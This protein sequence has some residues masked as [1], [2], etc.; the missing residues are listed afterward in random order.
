[1]LARFYVA[2]PFS[3]HIPEGEELGAYEYSDNGY[4]VRFLPPS[5]SDKPRGALA[6]SEIWINGRRSVSCDALCIEFQK[7]EFDR[8]EGLLSDPSYEFLA[9]TIDSFL[10]RLRHVTRASFVRL[11]PFPNVP[12]RLEYLRDDGSELN[13]EEGLVRGRGAV[14]AAFTYVG[15]T[16]EVWN[17]V[18]HLDP[19]YEPHTWEELLLNAW[20]ALPEVGPSSRP[21]SYCARSFH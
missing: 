3:I 20:D 7:E 21:C 14:S 16:K 13:Q 19:N 10:T 1:M 11:I 12:W 2:V 18:H 17:D 6:D 15:L 8:S 4:Q 9:K 5:R